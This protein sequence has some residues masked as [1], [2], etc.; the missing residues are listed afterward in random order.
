MQTL[1]FAFAIVGLLITYTD[2]S[3]RAL[4]DEPAQWKASI[5]RPTRG[6]DYDGKR[7][8][9]HI[10]Y[11][12]YLWDATTGELLHSMT[13]HQERIQV[14]QFSPDGH[15]ALSSSWM[16]PGPMQPMRISKDT[17]TILWNLETGRKRYDLKGEVAGEFSPDGKRVVTFSQRS[18]ESSSFDAAV[19]DTLTG[20]GLVT[21]KLDDH[22][23]P[24]WDTLHFSPDGDRF[25]Y[26][27]KGAYLL[28]NSSEAVLYN[29]S[30]G[31][32]MGRAAARYGI[33]RYTSGGAL[34][35]FDSE[36]G[37]LVAIESG[38]SLQSF[39]H[40]LKANWCG[41]WT[42]DGGKVAAFPTNG[43]FKIWDMESGKSIAGARAGVY[44][45]NIAFISPDN[46][47]LAIA[48]GGVNVENREIDPAF[49]LYDMNSGA[50][51]ATIQLAEH[52]S[53]I[54]FS[55]D[56]K[57][58]LVGGYAYKKYIAENE[59]RT[60]LPEF[61]IYDAVDGKKVRTLALSLPDDVK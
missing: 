30:N 56:S 8:L 13:G 20:R 48:W 37:S 31:R 10:G 5:E 9:G 43:A 60:I 50:E 47:R 18:I 32:E 2:A 55:P 45:R 17:R 21:V 52:A 35:S 7:I 61:A 51:I 22:S 14:V 12:I 34:A 28:F 59:K 3:G 16:P 24:Y 57:T 29:T 26:F 25:I 38:R 15:H 19:W 41:A 23:G 36:R 58:L 27:K 40:G 53:L 33:H 49:G 6:W 44:P 4:A 54:G 39:E 1:A 11:D 46:R 42:H